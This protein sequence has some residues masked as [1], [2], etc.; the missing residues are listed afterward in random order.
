MLS[1]RVVTIP[2]IFLG[3]FFV[4]VCLVFFS[5]SKS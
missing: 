3:F 1:S 4:V 5:K 2:I